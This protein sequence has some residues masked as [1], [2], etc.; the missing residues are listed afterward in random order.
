MRLN[1]TPPSSL[2]KAPSQE[3]FEDDGSID[4]DDLETS[5]DSATDEINIEPTRENEAS[6]SYSIAGFIEKLRRRGI[7][8]GAEVGWLIQNK[9]KVSAY[10]K[11]TILTLITGKP[12]ANTFV[13]YWLGQATNFLITSRNQNQWLDWAKKN[14]SHKFSEGLF[15]RSDIKEL[16]PPKK[17]KPTETPFRDSINDEART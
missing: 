7:P 8:D 10:Q 9:S 13:A 12:F 16:L 6:R 11:S 2:S 17:K 15:N 4:D 3:V 14:R 5:E 1:P